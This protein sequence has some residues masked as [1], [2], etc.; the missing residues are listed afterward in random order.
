MSPT[1]TSKKF[2]FKCFYL[3]WGDRETECEQGRGRESGD[4]ESEA[5]SGLRAVSADPGMGLEPMNCEI[6]TLAEVRRLT[7]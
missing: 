4:T 7:N 3:F 5:G 1:Y 2:F 6:M